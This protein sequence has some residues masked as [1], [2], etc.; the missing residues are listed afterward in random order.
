MGGKPSKKGQTE[1]EGGKRLRPS[2]ASPMWS[3]RGHPLRGRAG[4]QPPGRP[5]RPRAAAAEQSP[6]SPPCGPVRV[7]MRVHVPSTHGR[8][9]LCPSVRVNFESLPRGTP[10]RRAA[11]LGRSRVTRTGVH[12]PTDTGLTRL[13]PQRGASLPGQGLRPKSCRLFLTAGARHPRGPAPGWAAGGF[14]E[15][16]FFVLLLPLPVLG[17]RSVASILRSRRRA[18]AAQ[19]APL[20]RGSGAG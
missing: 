12:P 7:W 18:P 14:V 8:L 6:H 4:V 13:L 5:R 10:A 9:C 15:F 11:P 19:I 2:A 3:V 17:W 20:L 16:S 1:G